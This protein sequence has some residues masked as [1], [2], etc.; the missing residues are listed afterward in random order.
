MNYCQ[1]CG[2]SLSRITID[3]ALRYV[4]TVSDCNFMYW[5]NPIPVVAVLVRY[6]ACYIIARNVSWPDTIYS[7]ISGYLE[8]G[9]TPAEAVIR[10]IKEELG[11]NASVDAFLGHFVFKEKNQLL[12]AYTAIASGGDIALNHELA[13]IKQLSENELL[14]YD[15]GPLSIT[16][17]IIQEWKRRRVD[18]KGSIPAFT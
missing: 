9:E 4:C 16:K 12:L 5:N 15:F 11:L 7:L 13:A 8:Y 17:N 2:A 1:K 14:S 18:S 6:N 3:G 10:E